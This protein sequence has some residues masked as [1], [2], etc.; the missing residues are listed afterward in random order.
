[1]HWHLYQWQ[2]HP[3]LVLD[4]FKVS[5]PH[6]RGLLLT[7]QMIPSSLSQRQKAG[8]Y[9]RIAEVLVM[10]GLYRQRCEQ[11]KI[12]MAIIRDR[13][14]MSNVTDNTTVDDVI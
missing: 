6:V 3:G 13:Q 4:Q 7:R 10:P 1:M 11:L 9:I 2:T 14:P 12:A 5:L 8:L